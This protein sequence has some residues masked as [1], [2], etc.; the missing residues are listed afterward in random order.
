MEHVIVVEF[1]IH[2]IPD[3]GMNRE[4]YK[5]GENYIGYVGSMASRRCVGLKHV[6]DDR[7]DYVE[8]RF[9]DGTFDRIYNYTKIVWA[10]EP[11]YNRIIGEDDE[12]K[13]Q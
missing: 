7:G 2:Y 8:A 5:I 3:Y 12:L 4:Y 9:N 10:S 6:N 13:T 1:N 11:T